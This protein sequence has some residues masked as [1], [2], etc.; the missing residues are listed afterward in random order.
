MPAPAA[1]TSVFV[2][3]GSGYVGR[4]LISRL[5]DR[6]HPVRALVRP[7]SESK[8]PHGAEPVLGNALDA[9]SFAA[10]IAPALTL[11]HLVGTPH[12]NP[13]KAR[14]F[15]DI[16]L[17]SV[18][19]SVMAAKSG[20]VRHFVYVS[21]AHPAP[22]MHAYIAA[23]TAGE[24]CV[25]ESGIPA[26]LLRPWYI[27]GPGHRWPLLL[28]PLYALLERIPST[29][30]SALRLGLVTREQMAAALVV[31]VESPAETVNIVGVPDIRA[32]APA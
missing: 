2:T 14:E 24:T 21:V 15:R 9:S 26:T 25:R 7:G 6:G 11:V 13:S 18:Q 12:P 5:V 8:L 4:A 27:V 17:A 28:S 19:A 29:R 20:G 23:R 30:E 31:A 32:A 16:D 22:V 10:R 3:G 1:K